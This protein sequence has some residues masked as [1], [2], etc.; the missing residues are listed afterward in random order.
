MGR[1]KITDIDLMNEEFSFSRIIK[2]RIQNDEEKGTR[3]IVLVKGQLENI[4]RNYAIMGT[5][6]FQEITIKD[7][8]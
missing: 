5:N 6:Y 8:K 1:K 3:Y 4:L 7:D 2:R